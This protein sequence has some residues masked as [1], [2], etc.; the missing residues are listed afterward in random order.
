LYIIEDGKYRLQVKEFELPKIDGY[1]LKSYDVI[2]MHN[3]IVY[4]YNTARI[5]ETNNTMLLLMKHDLEGQLVDHKIH[6]IKPKNGIIGKAHIPNYAGGIN[7]HPRIDSKGELVLFGF[8][9]KS[10]YDGF[11]ER[12]IWHMRFDKSLAAKWHKES[13]FK[14]MPGI[15]KKYIEGFSDVHIRED[16][17]NGTYY[18]IANNTTS[19][20][21]FCT[22][23]KGSYTFEITK[24]GEMKMLIARRN[25]PDTY[26]MHKAEV[27]FYGHVRSTYILGN[28]DSWHPHTTNFLANIESRNSQSKALNKVAEINKTYS[29]S[30]TYNFKS[31]VDGSGL[32]MEYDLEKNAV[33]LWIVK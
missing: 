29:K 8:L 31:Y 7:V 33:K 1:D 21:P 23:S 15:S 11:R 22:D 5:G 3:S 12:G 14:D 17:A 32:S 25:V 30:K 10:S 9:A 26:D 24:E 13:M 16:V 27:R 6:V 2:G 28:E 19:N 18:L 4:T 20:K